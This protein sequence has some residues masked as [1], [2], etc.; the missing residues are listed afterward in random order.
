MCQARRR[1]LHNDCA[2]WHSQH[3]NV[4]LMGMPDI[5]HIL[6][7]IE[8]GNP[9]A[10]EELLPLVYDQLR[11]LAAENLTQ[12]KPGQTLQATALVHEAYIR[13]VDVDRQQQWESRRHF[14]ACAA[15]AMR[16]ILVE[17]ARRKKSVKRGGEFQRV[18]LPTDVVQPAVNADD[19]LAVHEA[20]E[21]LEAEDPQIAQL[22]KLRYFAGMSITAA[23]EIL[24]LSRTKAY[25]QWAYARAW[26][27]CAIDQ[28]QR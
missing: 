12:E 19:L 5:T 22:V 14:F 24:G 27:Q 13:L 23:A 6:A 16:R 7:E 18:E 28:P 3:A 20:V 8:R 25:Q 17:S 21:R 11:R 15:E 4:I 26:L 2:C 9:S 1:T 10:A